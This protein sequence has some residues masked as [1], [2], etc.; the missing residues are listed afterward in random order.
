MILR[1]PWICSLLALVS[2]PSLSSRKQSARAS[3]SQ[4]RSCRRCLWSWLPVSRPFLVL[5]RRCL[6]HRRAGPRRLARCRMQRLPGC[7]ITRTRSGRIKLPACFTHPIRVQ[8]KKESVKPHPH[9]FSWPHAFAFLLATCD[10]AGKS[11]LHTQ[12]LIN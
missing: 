11:F 5:G 4:A 10:K 9:A 8:E 2:S 6:P 7:P 3:S 1:N 12:V